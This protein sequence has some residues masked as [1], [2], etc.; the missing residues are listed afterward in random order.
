MIFLKISNGKGYFRNEKNEFVEIDAIHKE[1]IL[2]LLEVITLEDISF[3]MDQMED[4]NLQ[5]ATHK[6]IY[7]NIY[8]KFLELQKNKNR[9]L[10]ESEKLYKEALQRYQVDELLQ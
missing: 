2:R 8:E 10:D 7:K 3:E 9:F 5:N 1:D 6:I 4:N